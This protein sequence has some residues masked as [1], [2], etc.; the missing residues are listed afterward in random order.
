[1]QDTFCRFPLTEL[2]TSALCTLLPALNHIGTSQAHPTQ[3]TKQHCNRLMDY[4][5]TYPNAYIRYHAS[6]MILHVDSDAA[7][8][9]LPKAKSR[10]A[11]YFYLA[12][13]KPDT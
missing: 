12:D 6:K 5:Y 7:Y 11:G 1:M 4:A 10:I 13:L 2:Y 8:L 9:V 3:L